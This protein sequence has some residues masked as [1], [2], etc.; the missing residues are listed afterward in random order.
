MDVTRLVEEVKSSV[1]SGGSGL[2]NEDVYMSTTFEAFVDRVVLISRGG[3]EA[4]FEYDAVKLRVNNLD[5]EFPH[6]IFIGNQ[7]VDAISG[8]TSKVS[9][10]QITC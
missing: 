10:N 2:V 4:V 8:K 1:P 3:G 5:L 7:F 6:Q 9:A